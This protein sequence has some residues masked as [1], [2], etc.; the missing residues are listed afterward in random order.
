M[1]MVKKGSGVDIEATFQ[2]LDQRISALENKD[3]PQ[4][5]KTEQPKSTWTP[6]PPKRA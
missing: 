4:P 1:E 3:K 2:A 5:F 6:D